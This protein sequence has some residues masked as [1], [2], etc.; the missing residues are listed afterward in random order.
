MDGCRAR[1]PSSSTS[2]RSSLVIPRDVSCEDDRDDRDGGGGVSRRRVRDVGARE[3]VPE[4]GRRAGRR[5]DDG[6]GNDGDVDVETVVDAVRERARVEVD[7]RGRAR[8]RVRVDRCR[9][10]ERVLRRER[11]VDEAVRVRRVRREGRVLRGVRDVRVVL[12]RTRARSKERDEETRE[13]EKSSRD[14]VF[15]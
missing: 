6:N 2:Q 1:K 7:D 14:W 8:V 13:G 11:D 9:S 15:R 10:I 4:R 12:F 3:G 5:R